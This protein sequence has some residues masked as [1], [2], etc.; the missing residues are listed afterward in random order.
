MSRG[1]TVSSECKYVFNLNEPPSVPPR[2]LNMESIRDDEIRSSGD[3]SYVF[4][5]GVGARWMQAG[6]NALPNS[7]LA[8]ST[9][10][11]CQITEQ[12][13]CKNVTPDSSPVQSRMSNSKTMKDT[14][15]AR[16]PSLPPKS[17]SLMREQELILP[18]KKNR[19]IPFPPQIIVKTKKMKNLSKSILDKREPPSKVVPYKEH[20]I[21]KHQQSPKSEYYILNPSL[22]EAIPTVPDSLGTENKKHVNSGA[23]RSHKKLARQRS[24]GRRSYKKT[25]GKHRED[26]RPVH[27]NLKVKPHQ[28]GKYGS[29]NSAVSASPA[30]E[31]ADL[32]GIPLSS[33]TTEHTAEEE[34]KANRGLSMILTDLGQLLKNSKYNETDLLAAI[35]THLRVSVKTKSEVTNGSDTDEPAK[36]KKS[37][38]EY[39][40]EWLSGEEPES[41]IEDN[42]AFMNQ[43]EDDDSDFELPTRQRI[44]VTLA[45]KTVMRSSTRKWQA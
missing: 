3:Y 12:N 26:P 34:V 1:S 40:D 39:T 17:D 19:A 5:P 8:L 36:G 23:T 30:S 25:T 7:S 15:A 10:E 35:E 32:L 24:H 37:K 29:Q 13:T 21:L 28:R 4:I 31:S 14:A 20:K 6:G 43:S 45:K 18:S 22:N 41:E 42:V 16:P 9:K 33:N 2:P 38:N 11:T 27:E 44:L